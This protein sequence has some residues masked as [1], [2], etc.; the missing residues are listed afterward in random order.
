MDLAANHGSSALNPKP[1]PNPKPY[2]S[3]DIGTKVQP[4]LSLICLKFRA[5]GRLKFDCITRDGVEN[6]NFQGIG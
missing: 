3:S 6:L 4:D 1:N 5:L 2:K